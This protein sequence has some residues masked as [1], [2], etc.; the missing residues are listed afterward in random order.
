MK[1][2]GDMH[3]Q[4]DLFME[5]PMKMPQTQTRAPLRAHL[6]TPQKPISTGPC[7]NTIN[8]T[9]EETNR[10][11]TAR[12]HA[13]AAPMMHLNTNVDVH[14][15]VGDGINGCPDFQMPNDI[16]RTTV[17]FAS[18]ALNFSEMMDMDMNID[19]NLN[20]D[21]N[22]NLGRDFNTNTDPAMGM[23]LFQGMGQPLHMNANVPQTGSPIVH[24]GPSIVSGSSPELPAERPCALFHGRVRR[25][26]HLRLREPYT[27]RRRDPKRYC[28]A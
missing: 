23:D 8:E 15:S 26:D 18:P 10:R 2:A 4:A 16:G 25:D 21:M 1:T 12:N 28:H 9:L 14:A 13:A 20:G 24:A 3:E 27:H 11:T 5:S 22:M 7:P 17:N 6:P 19:P